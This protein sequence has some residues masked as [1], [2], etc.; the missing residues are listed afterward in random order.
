[1]QKYFREP[2]GGR[3]VTTHETQITFYWRPGCGFC[4]ALER[5]LQVAGVEMMFRNIWED[6]DAAAFVRN[7]AAG[8]EIVPTVEVGGAVMVNPTSEEVMSA[9]ATHQAAQLSGET[10]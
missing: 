3:A 8:N 2:Q 6:P 1:M 7:C 4:M 9:I 5:Q 10:S